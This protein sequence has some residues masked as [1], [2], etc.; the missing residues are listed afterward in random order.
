MKKILPG[1]IAL[2]VILGAVAYYFFFGGKERFETVLN[3][4]DETAQTEDQMMD[5]ERMME[6]KLSTLVA[7]KVV[8]PVLSVDQDAVW[9]FDSTGQL[10]RKEVAGSQSTESYGLTDPDFTKTAIWPDAGNNFIVKTLQAGGKEVYQVYL[11]LQTRFAEQ[12]ENMKSVDWMPDGV[13]IVYVWQRG[14]GAWELK[15]SDADGKNFSKIA[16]L[17]KFYEV[18]VSPTGVFALLVPKAASSTNQVLRVEIPSG[19]RS[20]LLD[21]GV[22][23]DVKFS[24]SG[25][26]LL[27]SRLD[28]DSQPE[29]WVYDF[30]DGS[31]KQLG[32]NTT[33]DKV[34]WSAD[35]QG[36]YYGKPLAIIFGDSNIEK[37]TDD[38]VMFYDLALQ[39]GSEVL[40][41]KPGRQIDVRDMSVSGDDSFLI[42]RNGW[43]G[44]LY[45]LLLK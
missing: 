20:A 11:A 37:Q 44:G 31:F 14:D 27:F 6:E 18:H 16:D 33:P 8:S 43:D 9:F 4:T 13:R 21:R 36:F 7:S 32:I 12:P 38:V 39:S 28:Q 15:M 42:F 41:R 24:P 3:K 17:D 23:V 2:L 10:Y 22:N 29:L 5:G 26:K 30:I 1:I 45:K 40:E 25:R 19:E 35:S 34:A